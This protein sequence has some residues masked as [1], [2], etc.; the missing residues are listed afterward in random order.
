MED[1]ATGRQPQE[2][3]VQNAP[4]PVRI[5]VPQDD[6]SLR[7]YTH[8]SVEQGGQGESPKARIAMPNQNGG[9]D[10]YESGSPQNPVDSTPAEVAVNASRSLE[11]SPLVAAPEPFS[12]AEQASSTSSIGEPIN[13][14]D[15]RGLL[16]ANPQTTSE[17]ILPNSSQGNADQIREQQLKEQNERAQRILER[18]PDEILIPNQPNLT[19]RTATEEA[20]LGILQHGLYLRS[21]EE[22]ISATAV[23]LSQNPNNR[24]MNAQNLAQRH[25]PRGEQS[26]FT[27]VMQF[28]QVTPQELLDKWNASRQNL[29]ANFP[30]LRAGDQLRGY[31]RFLPYVTPP[32]GEVKLSHVAGVLPAE[33]AVGVVDQNTGQ[34]YTREEFIRQFGNHS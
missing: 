20:V 32:Q 15:L 28:P 23:M 10:V 34:Y 12:P 5:A 33:Y 14:D 21:G 2:T 3:P 1:L 6:G 22:A 16:Q 27:V 4:T 11:E 25:S 8:S 24:E 17:T 31:D 19:H 18:V 26:R 7:T 9:F 30:G 13:M 29:P